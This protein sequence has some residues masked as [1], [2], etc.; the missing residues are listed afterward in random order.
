MSSGVVVSDIKGNAPDGEK[1]MCIDVLDFYAQ[2]KDHFAYSVGKRL[3]VAEVNVG[4]MVN[5]KSRSEVVC[6]IM[7]EEGRRCP[8]KY[9]I[10]RAN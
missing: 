7:L 3:K 2:L 10:K 4:E 1:Q 6:E 5:G 8:N 9:Y